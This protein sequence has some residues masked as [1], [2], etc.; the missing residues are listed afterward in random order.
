MVRMVVSRIAFLLV[1]MIPAPCA[2]AQDR[3]GRWTLGCGVTTSYDDN[4]LEYSERDVFAFR[5]AL[6]P[7]R[8]DLKTIDDLILQPFG[9]LAWK[10]A[11]TG[12]TSI[13]LRALGSLFA[14]N[15]IRDHA[16][17]SLRWRQRLVRGV[18][19][20]LE[21]AYLS[22]RYSRQLRDDE[23]PVPFPMLSQYRRADFREGELSLG[24]LWSPLPEWS[25]K[26][27]VGMRRREYLRSFS[28]R[29]LHTR[30]ANLSMSPPGM[31]GFRAAF[32]LGYR[33]SAARAADGDEV[34]GK[35]DDPDVSERGPSTGASLEW[36]LRSALPSLRIT[37]SYGLSQLRYTTLDTTD[38]RRF[39]RMRKFHSWRSS[40]L[41]GLSSSW[42]I[43]ATYEAAGWDLLDDG[44]ATLLAADLRSMRVHRFGV[45][46]G[47]T[48]RRPG[49]G[50]ESRTED[51]HE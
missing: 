13:R 23:V 49:S 6:V 33:N 8:F 5:H 17:I 21:G 34:S 37:E 39:H 47:W 35:R 14:M 20:S 3:P 38:R 1:C 26:I 4:I 48:S 42:R 25:N 36:S 43:R 27:E 40:V 2:W 11:S 32:Q 50:V 41:V 44:P 18:R 16:R 45:E 15:G 10:S 19:L 51:F 30:V 46:L 9:E 24:C 31:R 28:E 7:S 22:P 29:D 12:S